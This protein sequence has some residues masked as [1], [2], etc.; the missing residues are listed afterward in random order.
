[1]KLRGNRKIEEYLIKSMVQNGHDE[2]DGKHVI[3]K[4]SFFSLDQL[5]TNASTG[6]KKSIIELRNTLLSVFFKRLI[7]QRTD[8]L[9][10]KIIKN[11]FQSFLDVN[12]IGALKFIHNDLGC[13]YI[14]I[15]FTVNQRSFTGIPRVVTELVRRGASSGLIPIM[16]YNKMFYRYDNDLDLLI[17]VEFR[18]NDLLLLADAGWNYSDD[19]NVVIDQISNTGG[20][21]VLLLYDLIPI[22]YPTL[23]NPDHVYAF[24]LW[25][26]II[27]F[28]CH[29]V[30]CI[31]KSV[32]EEL[33]SELGYSNPSYSRLLSIGWAHLGCDFQ[34]NSKIIGCDDTSL[35]S[36]INRPY[37]LSVGTVEPRKA[38]SV[39]LDAMEYVWAAGFDAIYVIVG[40]YGWSQGL[41][42][43]RIMSHSEY[44]KRL[45][46]L[47]SASDNELQY[48]YKNALALVSS[49]LCEGFGLPLIEA[50]HYNLASIVSDIPVFREIG[51]R[52]TQYFEVTNSQELANLLSQTLLKPKLVPDIDFLTWDVSVTN[53]LS[54]ICD[55]KYQ[56]K[57]Y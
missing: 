19:L 17:S 5:D 21:C 18:K 10:S 23:S 56:H 50:A 49:S 1:M 34:N 7:K 6:F 12:N 14:D 24:S 51:G 43:E 8:C 38:Y 16:L 41:L 53:L 37:F 45:F 52:S 31:S 54:M 42:K 15:T 28:K 4:H 13:K 44:G 26:N 3:V 27:M 9:G 55:N 36:I 39:A 32:A 22:T 47:D 25:I 30:I 48:L 11:N 40:K 20:K 46:W 33:I 57:L 29:H 2:D 35:F